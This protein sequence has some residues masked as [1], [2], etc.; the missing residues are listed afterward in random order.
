MKKTVLS[1]LAIVAFAAVAHA[2]DDS[3]HVMAA[4]EG[5]KL[6]CVKLKFDNKV[7]QMS[8]FSSDIQDQID[9]LAKQRA[10]NDNDAQERQQRLNQ[11]KLALKGVVSEMEEAKVTAIKAGQ[12]I[13]QENREVLERPDANDAAERAA[14]VAK[15]KSAFEKFASEVKETAKEAVASVKAL[16]KRLGSDDND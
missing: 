3:C 14:R 4:A 13:A 9:K 10:A 15:V 5:Q 12:R 2:E 8:K 1:L 11:L 16:I 7:T 6:A